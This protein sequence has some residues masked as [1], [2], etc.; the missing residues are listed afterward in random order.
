MKTACLAAFA[1]VLLSCASAQ[2]RGRAPSEYTAFV[3][4]A[5]TSCGGSSRQLA[6]SRKPGF[7]Q[8]RAAQTALKNRVPAY[9]AGAGSTVAA[10]L[11]ARR[12]ARRARTR[13]ASPRH[14]VLGDSN[15]R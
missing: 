14:G 2:R 8:G 12:S 4:F 9:H 11:R 5:A 1:L 13:S 15:S 6:E 3:D 10:A 7:D